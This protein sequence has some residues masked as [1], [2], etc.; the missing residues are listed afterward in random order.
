MTAEL[1][2]IGCGLIDRLEQCGLRIINKRTT[3][4]NLV[5]RRI[6]FD[7]CFGVSLTKAHVAKRPEKGWNS[8]GG[9]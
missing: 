9:P 5:S 6:V 7:V 8:R 1:D 4:A 2:E 3:T